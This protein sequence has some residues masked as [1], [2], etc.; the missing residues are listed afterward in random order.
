MI[1]SFMSQS[2]NN[3]LMKELYLDIETKPTSA[4][5]AAALYFRITATGMI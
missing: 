4:V 5:T 1:V 2:Q 3:L